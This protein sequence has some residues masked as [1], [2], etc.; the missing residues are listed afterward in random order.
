MGTLSG[1]EPGETNVSGS[2]ASAQKKKKKKKK[3][4]GRRVTRAERADLFEL[5]E[6]SVQAP[7]VD[8]EFFDALYVERFG[9]SPVSLR[10]DFCGSAALCRAWAASSAE[11]TAV[12]VDLDK[13]TLDWARSRLQRE[14]GTEAERVQ[15]TEGD[16][17][18]TGGESVDVLCAQNFSYFVFEE[19]KE[20]RSYFERCRERVAEP[21]IFIVDLF[22]G[23]ESIEDER[24]DVTDHGDFEY[25]WEQHRYDPINAHGIYKI[26]FRFPDGSTLPDAFVYEWR[27][28]T[29]PE[30]REL[31]LE[32]GFAAADV[33]WEDEDPDTGEGLG[34]YSLQTSAACDPAW[35]AYVVGRR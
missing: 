31:M 32:A 1:I 12:G 6:R 22:G 16:V 8:V 4:A 20:L 7:E 25:V 26:H 30:V 28:W 29:I 18:T 3:S 10:E 34:S 5:Y 23:Y 35:N 21:G 24:E 15:L 17:R 2:R 33:Y 27:L 11:R 14:L 13:E 9:E 19:R